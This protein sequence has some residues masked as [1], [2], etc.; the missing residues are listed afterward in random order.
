MIFVYRLGEKGRAFCNFCKK[1]YSSEGVLD[2]FRIGH[3]PNKRSS[4][5]LSACRFCLSQ[6]RNRIDEVLK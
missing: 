1:K 6:L 3:S 4:A 5:G 2:I